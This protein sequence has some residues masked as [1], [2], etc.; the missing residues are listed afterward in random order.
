MIIC[1][2]STQ[3]I[4]LSPLKTCFWRIFNKWENAA[5]YGIISFMAGKIRKSSIFSFECVWQFLYFTSFYNE[6]VLFFEI[7][8]KNPRNS[9]R[10]RLGP[11]PWMWSLA[12]SGSVGQSANMYPVP[13]LY[14]AR[15]Q[16]LGTQM[17]SKQ[18]KTPPPRR[19][20]ALR[21]W[22]HSETWLYEQMQMLAVPLANSNCWYPTENQLNRYLSMFLKSEIPITRKST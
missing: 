5:F 6:R 15:G 20:A 8:G 16:T 22:V 13:T 17:T 14:Q 7:G 9:G 1:G 2:T 11:S 21:H 19:G 4:I 18:N 10:P 3:W 12:V